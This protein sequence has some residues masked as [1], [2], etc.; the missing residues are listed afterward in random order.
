MHQNEDN[1]PT[2]HDDL[3]QPAA[4]DWGLLQSASIQ[5]QHPPRVVTITKLHMMGKLLSDGSRG[6][7]TGGS[8]EGG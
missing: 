5:G 1:V 8:W 3:Q 4:K 7:G 2:A 6:L